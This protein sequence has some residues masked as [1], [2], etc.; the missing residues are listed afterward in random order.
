MKCKIIEVG[1]WIREKIP[2]WRNW[3]SFHK[4]WEYVSFWEF[5]LKQLFPQFK[6]NL[7]FPYDHNS[8][9]C[10]NIIVGKNCK[11]TQR[12]GCYIQGWGKIF[13]G[14]YVEITQNCIIISRNHKLTNQGEY[15]DYETIIGDHCWIASNSLIMGGG[16]FRSADSSRS[17]KCCYQEFS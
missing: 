9:C 14:D 13:I 5:L 8:T 10:G 17:R 1:K 11:V 3:S 12:G 15:T 7:Y 16:S 2:L 4:T 6:K